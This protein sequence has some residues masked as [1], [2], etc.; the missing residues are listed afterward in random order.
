MRQRHEGLCYRYG[1]SFK[2]QEF[3]GCAGFESPWLAGQ[4]GCGY[5]EGGTQSHQRH[6]LEGHHRFCLSQRWHQCLLPKAWRRSPESMPWADGNHLGK[7]CLATDLPIRSTI[8]RCEDGW[9]GGEVVG[10]EAGWLSKQFVVHPHNCERE[11]GGQEENPWKSGQQDGGRSREPPSNDDPGCFPIHASLQHSQ[12]GW[13]LLL[14]IC[15]VTLLRDGLHPGQLSIAQPVSAKPLSR[16]WCVMPLNLYTRRW[17]RGRRAW[18]LWRSRWSYVVTCSAATGART[19]AT[20]SRTS[21]KAA[22]STWARARSGPIANTA[23]GGNANISRIPAL[24]VQKQKS[25]RA[26]W[27]GWRSRWITFGPLGSLLC[28]TT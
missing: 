6:C 19:N 25:G 7:M 8:C 15:R 3:F 12:G 28:P 11:H 9:F 1:G 22:T 10:S 16:S 13:T 17:R 21:L 14:T 4:V 2:I 27:T 18:R 5:I 23:V 26:M 20:T 24:R